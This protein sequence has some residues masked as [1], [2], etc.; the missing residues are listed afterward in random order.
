MG[1][2]GPLMEDPSSPERIL[3]EDLVEDPSAVTA[4]R[5]PLTAKKN[6]PLSV[7]KAA[8]WVECWAVD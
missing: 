6:R 7:G 2:D 4:Y 1:A 3:V 5:L 8:G